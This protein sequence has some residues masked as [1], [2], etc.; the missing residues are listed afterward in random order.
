M[1]DFDASFIR[2]WLALDEI[3]AETDPELRAMGLKEPSVIR[4]AA[5]CSWICRVFHGYIGEL[6]PS[7]LQRIRTRLSDWV[8]GRL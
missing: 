5:S 8:L 3:I 1:H 2:E 7:R 4:V 6:A